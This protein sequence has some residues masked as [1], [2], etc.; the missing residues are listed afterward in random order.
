MLAGNAGPLAFAGGIP[1]TRAGGAAGRQNRARSSAG[2]H[3]LH[4]AGVAG[5][6]PAAPTNVFKDLAELFHL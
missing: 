2:E 3:C 6:N 5:S 1:V 4:T